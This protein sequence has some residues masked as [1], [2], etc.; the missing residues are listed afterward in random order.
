MPHDLQNSEWQP[1][2]TTPALLVTRGYQAEMLHQSLAKNTI[3]ALETGSGKTHIAVLR[4]KHEMEKDATKVHSLFKVWP[5]AYSHNFS[6]LG[7][8]LR[9]SPSAFNSTV[10]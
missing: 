2:A 5:V 6:F 10:F 1:P 3:I 9:L 4:L 7:L 8:S